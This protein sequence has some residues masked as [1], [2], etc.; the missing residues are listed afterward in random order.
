MLV[1]AENQKKMEAERRERERIEDIRLA[2][3]YTKLLEE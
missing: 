3:E 2:E 1:D